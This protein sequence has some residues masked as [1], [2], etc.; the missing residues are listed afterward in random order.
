M[1]VL[2]DKLGKNQD[3]QPFLI[4]DPSGYN[5]AK[6][7]YQPMGQSAVTFEPMHYNDPILI[8]F[9]ICP[10]PVEEEDRLPNDDLITTVCVKQSLAFHGSA[11][12][13]LNCACI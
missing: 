8:S 9:E 1:L 12:K 5:S 13:F 6:R 2:S 3:R 4:T 10:K 11:N 7:Q